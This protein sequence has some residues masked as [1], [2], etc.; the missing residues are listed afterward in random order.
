M[1]V[2][3]ELTAVRIFSWL[4]TFATAWL[5]LNIVVLI[6]HIVTP[7]RR[8]EYNISF[9]ESAVASESSPRYEFCIPLTKYTLSIQVIQRKEKIEW[10]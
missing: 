4:G 6:I 7:S 10:N 9:E 3:G 8:K 1:F 2:L 5:L